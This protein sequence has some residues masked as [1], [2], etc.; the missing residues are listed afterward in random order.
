[1]TAPDGLGLLEAIARWLA[2]RGLSIEA[3]EITTR[4]GVANDRFLVDG[5]FDPSALAHHLSRRPASPWSRLFGGCPLSR[6][7]TG[8]VG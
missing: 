5:E 7:L 2:E 6:A 1:M 4:D 3:A 8:A